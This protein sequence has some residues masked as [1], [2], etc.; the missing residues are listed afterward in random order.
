[1][2]SRAIWEH[3]HCP[4]R[5]CSE[6]IWCPPKLFLLFAS[7]CFPLEINDAVPLSYLVQPDLDQ[8]WQ[9]LVA[10]VWGGA[11]DAAVKYLLHSGERSCL[12]GT[13]G[14]QWPWDGANSR[15]PQPGWREK[16]WSH[17]PLVI[18]FF[19]LMIGSFFIP[20]KNWAIGKAIIFSWRTFQ[21][22]RERGWLKGWCLNWPKNI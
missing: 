7:F 20:E 17:W 3:A 15:L 4:T 19:P 16:E 21:W 10:G 22:G 6:C 1:M 2:P 18:T 11:G 12:A 8:I 9:K 14:Q 5:W 13:D